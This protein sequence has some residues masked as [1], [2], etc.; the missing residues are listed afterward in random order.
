MSVFN[1]GK[2]CVFSE[3][4]ARVTENGEPLKNAVIV[5]KWEW[6]DLHEERATTDENGYFEFSAVFERSVARQFLPVE[7]VIAQG[8]YVEQGGNQT[9]FWSN[10]K[11]EPEENAELGGSPINLSCELTDEMKIT[12]QYGSIMNTLCTL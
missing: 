12:R 6:R 9:K 7:L 3:V 5:R 2:V 11:R 8:L 4:K 1:V 10:S